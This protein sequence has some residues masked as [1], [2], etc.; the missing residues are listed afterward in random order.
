MNL[1][2]NILKALDYGTKAAKKE[3]SQSCF[4][5]DVDDD[6]QMNESSES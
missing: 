5:G 4:A 2:C 1:N 6:K 3:G